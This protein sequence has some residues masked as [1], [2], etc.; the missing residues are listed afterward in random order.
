MKWGAWEGGWGGDSQ[1][2]RTVCLSYLLGVKNA[3]LAPIM[4]FSLKRSAAEAFV[5]PFRVS[6]RENVTGGNVFF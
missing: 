6:S 3:V 5:V 2:K 4:V 1:V